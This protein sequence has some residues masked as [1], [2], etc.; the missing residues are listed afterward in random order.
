MTRATVIRLIF[1]LP[2]IALG[3]WM[4][5]ASLGVTGHFARHA[6]DA[7]EWMGALIG[8]LFF[9]GASA[10]LINMLYGAADRP[11]GQLPA[12]TPAF[13]RIVSGA[14]GIAVAL[15]LAIIFV[16]VGFGPGERHFSGSGAFLGPF[17]GRAVFGLFGLLTFLV[18]GWMGFRAL[19]RT[20][21]ERD[22]AG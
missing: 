17:V 11:D 12:N 21:S 3:G 20:R 15:G 19:K 16:W 14:L 10:A 18:V 1:L 9:G 2:T 5:L 8:F 13:V 7:P 6:N 22:T 4:M